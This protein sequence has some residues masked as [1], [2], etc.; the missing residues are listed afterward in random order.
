[1][2]KTLFLFMAF[3]VLSV[4]NAKEG[5]KTVKMCSVEWPPYYGA[6]LKENGF[7]AAVTSAALKRVGYKM[8]V[9]FMPWARCLKNVEKGKDDAV[10]G[11]YFSEKREKWS[12]YS[13]PVH[14]VKNYF[15]S[16]KKLNL[17][18][19]KEL[20]ELKPFSI[21]V[22]RKWKYE[23]KFDKY[24]GLT[25][26]V[27]NKKKQ[28]LKLLFADRVDIVV[29]NDL[30][31]MLEINESYA[32]KKSNVVFMKPPLSKMALHNIF[33]K[34]TPNGEKMRSDFNKGLKSIKEDGT[35]DKIMS[36]YGLLIK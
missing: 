22:V 18:T 9:S 25:K 14:W 6:E 17:N 23:T 27:V 4:G 33:S 35:L 31:A 16:K 29:M 8:D 20:K 7:Y 11:A 32:G 19:Y 21:G 26:T 3:L 1:M 34:K 24:V 30:A 10:L 2:K 5:S 12:Y 15:L 28:L 13:E 36:S